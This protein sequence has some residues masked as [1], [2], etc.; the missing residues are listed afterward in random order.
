MRKGYTLMEVITVMAIIAILAAIGMAVFPRAK[1][2]AMKSSDINY[3]NELRTA[4]QLYTADQGGYPPQLLGY[5]NFYQNG[6]GVIPADKVKSYLSPSRVA[7]SNLNSTANNVSTSD[8]TTATWPNKDFSLVGERPMLDLNGDRVVTS[9]D[10]TPESRQVFGPSD[11]CF[12]GPSTVS[13]YCGN[14]SA[15]FYTVGGYGISRNPYPHPMGGAFPQYELRYALF[16]T[17][18][19]ASGVGGA[20]DDP[21]QLGYNNPPDDTIITWNTWWREWESVS[22]VPGI[23]MSPT[24]GS[25]D[26]LLT[27]GGNSV[28]VPSRAMFARSWRH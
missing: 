18:A 8:L 2:S 28:N 26:M 20:A 14:D 7:V 13:Q 22:M 25:R 23:N 5:V 21:R 24:N 17:A 11:G 12:S 9:I 3:L 6:G 10:D 1:R 15:L 27:V 4:T 16:W 19:G